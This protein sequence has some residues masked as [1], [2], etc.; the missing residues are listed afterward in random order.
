MLIGFSFIALILIGVF[1]DIYSLVVAFYII[2]I[3]AVATFACVLII[4]KVYSGPK[5]ESARKEEKWD[6][7]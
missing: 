2:M 5:R 4:A 3:F 1:G 6:F 7:E